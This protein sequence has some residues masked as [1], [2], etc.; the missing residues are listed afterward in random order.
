MT[1]RY[2]ARCADCALWVNPGEG[3]TKKGGS[4]RWNT[5]HIECPGD[6]KDRENA[7]AYEYRDEDNA[8]AYVS[9]TILDSWRERNASIE[10]A[11]DRGAYYDTTTYRVRL[12][13]GI[14]ASQY[15]SVIAKGDGQ[16]MASYGSFGGYSTIGNVTDQGD[17]TALVTSVY[18][19]GD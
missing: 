9:A 19:I 10:V 13:K 18:H 2:G 1:N 4:T 14:T 17:G 7:E 5:T 3:K 15:R 12:P 11:V 16:S 8:D 6:R